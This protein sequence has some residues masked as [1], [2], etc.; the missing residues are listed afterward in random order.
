MSASDSGIGSVGIGPG[1]IDP[2]EFR[3]ETFSSEP[4]FYVAVLVTESTSDTEGYQPWYEESFVL[5]KAESDAEAQEKAIEYGKSMGTS[6]QDEHHQLIT[7]RLKRIVEVKRVEDATF[8]DGTELYS[9]LFRNYA[10]Y[11]SLDALADE[12]E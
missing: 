4:D 11:E 7:W 10:G 12:D 5:V 9:R 8:D 2:R 6:Y 1:T 3:P